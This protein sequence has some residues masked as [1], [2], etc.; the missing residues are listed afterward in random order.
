M[1]E[2]ICDLFLLLSAGRDQS[3]SAEYVGKDDAYPGNLIRLL[4]YAK[5][6][7][8]S[9]HDVKWCNSAR[10]A[11]SMNFISCVITLLQQ[12]KAM[13]MGG[14]W[15]MGSLRSGCC[16][17]MARVLIPNSIRSIIVGH[18]R[19]IGQ[20]TE[21][22]VDNKLAPYSRQLLMT[23]EDQLKVSRFFAWPARYT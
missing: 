18:T 17:A 20:A 15:T 21:S 10:G 6:T 12:S 5:P 4:L 14:V 3:W 9:L 2:G 11:N 23:L 19:A 13:V 1:N 16:T 22:A 7:A 8:T